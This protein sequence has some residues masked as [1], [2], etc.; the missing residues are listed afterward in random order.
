MKNNK[1]LI[2]GIGSALVERAM[3]ALEQEGIRKVAL[4]VFDRNE[5]GNA[6]WE[7]LGFTKREDL[8][9]RNKSLVELTRIDT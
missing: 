3:A 5:I 4:V 1:K 8:I 9:Y 6:F 7:L 2:V